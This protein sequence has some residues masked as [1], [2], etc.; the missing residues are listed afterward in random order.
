[1]IC[2]I[3]EAL[4]Y[5]VLVF[6][7]MEIDVAELESEMSTYEA[8]SSYSDYAFRRSLEAAQGDPVIADEEVAP[9]KQDFHSHGE[10]SRSVWDDLA[11]CESGNWIDGGSS[12][13]EN[14]VRWYWARPGTEVPPWGTRIHHGGLQFH[15]D[16]WN[17]VAPMVGL[18]HIKYAYDATREEQILVAEKVL[19]LQ[20][21]GAWPT[22]AKKLGLR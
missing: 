14:S 18:G 2:S 21:W 20:G 22:C 16:T 19:E 10:T 7:P 13:E 17:W 1:M 11:D 9:S 12:F 5:L 3:P 4:A 6:C 8:T 15:P